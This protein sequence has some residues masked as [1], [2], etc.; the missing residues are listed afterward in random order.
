LKVYAILRAQIRSVNRAEKALIR[1]EILGEIVAHSPQRDLPSPLT[2]KRDSSAFGNLPPPS[3]D[4]IA[5][6]DSVGG[7]VDL[8]SPK[9]TSNPSST[10]PFDA[11]TT[12]RPVV[13]PPVVAVV[14]ASKP[15][16]IPTKPVLLNSTA[17]VVRRKPPT[18]PIPAA[19]IAFDDDL[20]DLV[21]TARTP[22]PPPPR[23][24][25]LVDQL[26]AVSLDD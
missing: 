5:W 1:K 20:N 25:A 10:N 9:S 4:E 6:W 13:T 18:I 8:D 2:R 17:P 24:S 12:V 7:L 14:S 23:P 21:T 22:P 16:S 3:S 26:S 15:P 11:P 19:S